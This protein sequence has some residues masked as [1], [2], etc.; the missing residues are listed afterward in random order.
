MMF[1]K[2]SVSVVTAG[3]LQTDVSEPQALCLHSRPGSEAG[4][5]T[6]I[7]FITD[8]G[9]QPKFSFLSFKSDRV[10]IFMFKIENS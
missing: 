2:V 6:I 4:P 3:P 8:R 9:E 1:L 5:G 7:V 10:N